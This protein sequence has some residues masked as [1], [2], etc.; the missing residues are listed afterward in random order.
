MNYDIRAAEERAEDGKQSCAVS[1]LQLPS[2]SGGEFE[3]VRLQNGVSLVLEFRKNVRS[4][5]G[6]DLEEGISLHDTWMRWVE[7]KQDEWKRK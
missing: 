1:F 7:K 4:K 3:G 6:D 5:E 2:E